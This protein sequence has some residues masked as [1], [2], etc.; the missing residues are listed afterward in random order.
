[1]LV[2]IIISFLAQPVCSEVDKEY[3]QAWQHVAA[4]RVLDMPL[5]QEEAIIWHLDYNGFAV[6]LP[7]CLM[8]FDYDNEAPSP[9]WETYQKPELGLI[10]SLFT[11][12]IDLEEIKNEKVMFLFSHNHPAE[13]FKKLLSWK[14]TIRDVQFLITQDDYLAH[15]KEILELQEKEK[16]DLNKKP[17]ESVIKIIKPNHNYVVYG[18]AIHVKE[19]KAILDRDKKFLYPGVEFLIDTNNGLIVYHSGSL[20]CRQCFGNL[21]DKIN[22]RKLCIEDSAESM[23]TRII[24]A[25]TKKIRIVNGKT[26]AVLSRDDN[27]DWPLN[28]A[29]VCRLALAVYS[30]PQAPLGYIY[31]YV[32]IGPHAKYVGQLMGRSF[33]DVGCTN[34]D[35]VRIKAFEKAHLVEMDKFYNDRNPACDTKLGEQ[36]HLEWVTKE[37]N[38]YFGEMEGNRE[39]IESLMTADI[40]RYIDYYTKSKEYAELGVQAEDIE[41]KLMWRLHGGEIEEVACGVPS[42]L[43]GETF[44]FTTRADWWEPH[45]K[46]MDV[47]FGGYM[48]SDG[49]PTFTKYTIP[50]KAFKECGYNMVTGQGLSE[51]W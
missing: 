32:S 13:K 26:V 36:V 15:E 4:K 51:Y 25:N 29:G 7:S 46:F 45:P 28:T 35:F 2:F 11:G 22:K 39:V 40:N 47:F 41:K 24:D 20:M 8:I 30:D 27:E 18:N 19:Q 9:Q 12:V 10:D 16:D 21:R 43:R 33:I 23:K 44:Y 49:S 3:T 42:F 1:M 48:D 34:A 17:V 31:M 14:D 6:R 50:W 38:E 5:K 37:I